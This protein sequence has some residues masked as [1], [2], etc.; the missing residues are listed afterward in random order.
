M[1]M[2]A[3]NPKTA[4]AAAFGTSGFLHDFNISFTWLRPG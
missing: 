1:F 4:S 3:K 2:A